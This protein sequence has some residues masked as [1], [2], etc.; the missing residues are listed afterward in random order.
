MN[1]VTVPR[2]PAEAVGGICKLKNEKDGSYI[3]INV[4]YN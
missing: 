1:S 3:T 4:E 2:I